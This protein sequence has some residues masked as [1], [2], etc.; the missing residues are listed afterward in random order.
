MHLYLSTTPPKGERLG[1]SLMAPMEPRPHGG[2]MT[3]S[4]PVG[5]GAPQ[6]WEGNG[7]LRENQGTEVNSAAD[8]PLAVVVIKHLAGSVVFALL[9]RIHQN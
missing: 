5:P 1:P 8:A 2:A 7:L 4:Q 3:S 6:R 9:S